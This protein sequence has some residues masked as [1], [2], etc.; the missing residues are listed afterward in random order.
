MLLLLLVF[1]QGL[2]EPELYG[3]KDK[4]LKYLWAGLILEINRIFCLFVIL[5][6]SRFGFE[7][8]LRFLTAPV[9][10][11]CSLATYVS[12]VLYWLYFECDATVGIFD[13]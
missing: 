10:V 12:N 7:G 9:P 13:K 1:K 6:I 5:V 4:N 8:G 11:H 2:S 3:D